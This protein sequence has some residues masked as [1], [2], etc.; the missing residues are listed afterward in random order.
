MEKTVLQGD[1]LKRVMDTELDD[2]DMNILL[3]GAPITKYGDLDKL[4][5]GNIIDDKGIGILI[6]IDEETPT[7][8][9]GHWLGVL[10]RGM[11]VEAFDP[12]GGRKDPWHLNKTFTD[13]ETNE[14]FNQ[15]RPL[16]A[17]L[18]LRSGLTPVYNTQR[19]QSMRSGIDTCGRH[20]AVRAMNRHMNIAEYTD[21]LESQGPPDQ[22]VAQ[23]TYS[24][25][26]H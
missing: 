12:Y 7:L 11:T 8:I 15:E 19:L 3:P 6:F 1:A 22:V 9:S 13:Y 24:K 18:I 25:L 2:A 20:V 21:W 10:R 26:G 4:T 17:N 23:I 5:L 16:L 14:E